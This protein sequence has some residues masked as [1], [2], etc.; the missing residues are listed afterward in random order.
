MCDFSL[1][2]DDVGRPVNPVVRLAKGGLLAPDIVFFDDFVFR[3]G[4]QCKGKVEFLY[5]FLIGLLRIRTH[6][7]DDKTAFGQERMV[8]PQVAGFLGAGRCIGLRIEIEHHFFAFEKLI[9]GDVF[10]RIAHAGVE[11]A[12]RYGFAGMIY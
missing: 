7:Q 6:A 3:V 12:A 2:V 1:F 4:Q 11:N 5:E 9:G 8:V 10:P